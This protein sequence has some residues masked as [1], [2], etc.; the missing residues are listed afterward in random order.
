M[1]KPEFIQNVINK[2]KNNEYQLNHLYLAGIQYK[3]GCLIGILAWEE[4]GYDP[5]ESTKL[6]RESYAK[7]SK[8]FILDELVMLENSYECWSSYKT[9]LSIKDNTARGIKILKDYLNEIS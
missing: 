8:F 3:R 7:L 6:F 5:E 9:Y 1:T 4:L 2:L